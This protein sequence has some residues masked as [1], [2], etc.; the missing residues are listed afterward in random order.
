[1]SKPRFDRFKQSILACDIHLK[2]QDPISFFS[3]SNIGR[4][5]STKRLLA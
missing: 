3:F 4:V 5:R 2:K 1:M